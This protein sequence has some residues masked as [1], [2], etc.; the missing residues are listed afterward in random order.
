MAIEEITKEE[1][2]AF[3]RIRNEGKYNMIMDAD[4][5]ASEAGLSRKKWF[6]IIQNYSELW[7]KFN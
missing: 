1:F 7:S 4:Q 3:N 2:N 6:D 5:A